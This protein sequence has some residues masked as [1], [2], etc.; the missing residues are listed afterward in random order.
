MCLQKYLKYLQE[1][2]IEDLIQSAASS[3]LE[4]LDPLLLNVA[5]SNSVY[6]DS[7]SFNCFT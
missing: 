1:V 6:D 2:N 7:S 5:Q 3:L 4:T